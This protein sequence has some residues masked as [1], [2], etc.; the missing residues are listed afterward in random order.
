MRG[1]LLFL[2]VFPCISF[3]QDVDLSDNQNI[4]RYHNQI[5]LRGKLVLPL[6]KKT[7]FSTQYISRIY[8]DGSAPG[9]F[10]YLSG[11]HQFKKWLI[12]D[13]T[14]RLVMD[15]GYNLYRLEVG[16]KV[17]KEIFKD[18]KI[19]YRTAAF[20]EVKTYAFSRELSKAPYFFWRN[21]I[22]VS[23]QPKKKWEFGT[24]FE[25]WNLFNYR[26]NGKL[27][28]ACVIV[29]AEYKLTK[30]QSFTVAYQNQFDIQRVKKVDLNMYCIGY[31]Y[32]LKKL[33]KKAH[34]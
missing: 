18:F 17:R 11:Q 19:A 22:E 32:T 14:G 23:W 30:H 31:I 28:K 25:V 5:W 1:L 12:A 7:E 4:Y 9:N 26:Y 21:R 29:D 10:F 6:N 27:D 3:G 20:R 34:S 33:K 15:Q 16:A 2:L 24:S 13:F 8:F